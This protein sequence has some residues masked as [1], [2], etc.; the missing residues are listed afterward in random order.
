MSKKDIKAPTKLIESPPGSFFLELFAGGYTDGKADPDL[1]IGMSNSHLYTR[2]AQ[3]GGKMVSKAL[4]MT[5]AT[6]VVFT[7]DETGARVLGP[8]THGRTCSLAVSPSDSST[9]AVTGWASIDTNAGPEDVFI[10]IDA[11]ASWT[12]HT[13]NLRQASGVVGKVRPG[14]LLFVDLLKNKDRALLVST[15]NGVLVSYLNSSSTTPT[16][17]RFGSCAD[18]PLVLTAALSYE[19]Y[20]DTLIAATFGRGIYTL[21]NAKAALLGARS[22]AVPSAPAP[23][24]EESSA[25]FFPPQQE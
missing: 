16:W 15:S 20:S 13:G 9:L 3:T 17:T 18:F 2:S 1:L 19:H 22:C 4:P 7:Y 11:G 14:G 6:P 5:Y 24:E 12:N 21:K 10:S 23:T 25:R 8:V